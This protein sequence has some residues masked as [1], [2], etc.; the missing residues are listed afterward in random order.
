VVEADSV[1]VVRRRPNRVRLR[2]IGRMVGVRPSW[3]AAEIGG[4]RRLCLVMVGGAAWWWPVV[5][6]SGRW[7]GNLVERGGGSIWEKGGK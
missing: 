6:V 7:R 2:E 3:W 4:G 1:G 5:V